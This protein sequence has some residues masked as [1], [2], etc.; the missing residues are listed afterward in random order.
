M[1]KIRL[2]KRGLAFLIV[3]IA[4]Y[5]YFLLTNI[6]AATVYALVEKQIGSNDLF[7]L[8]GLSGTIWSGRASQ[9]RIAQMNVGSLD[10][11][12]R[13]FPLLTGKL[14]LDI[15]T[16]A[17]NSRMQA[18]IETGLSG[19]TLA[20]DN[21]QGKLPVQALMPF[22]YGL[23]IAVD[24]EITTEI[25]HAEIE[26]GEKLI[27]DGKLVWQNAALTA[28]QAIKFGDLFLA[29]RPDKNGSKILLS[30]QGGPL[31][32]EGTAMIKPSGEYKLNIYLAARDKNDTN[33]S[34]ALKLLGRTNSQGKVRVSRT[35]RLQGWAKK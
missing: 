33:L 21:M 15:S 9:A 20:I 26:R 3:G 34:N 30:D 27:L 10:W 35:G 25:K 6:P 17:S 22:F 32:A 13:L 29:L 31:A 14:S 23:P 12:L 11:R 8:Q 18:G 19:Q 24:G 2:G 4:A 1:K 16:T 7:V 5:V 28:P